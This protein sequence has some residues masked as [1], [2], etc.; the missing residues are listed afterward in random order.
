MSDD[1]C[2]CNRLAV[3]EHL[4]STAEDSDGDRSLWCFGCFMEN[5]AAIDGEVYVRERRERDIVDP[6]QVIAGE[7]T[8]DVKHPPKARLV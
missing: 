7:V 6:G 3:I 8:I 2:N 1:C 5:F 4:P